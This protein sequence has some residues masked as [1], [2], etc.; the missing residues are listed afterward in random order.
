[1]YFMA[2]LS[3]VCAIASRLLALRWEIAPRSAAEHWTVAR[4]RVANVH[5]AKTGSLYLG[6]A[7]VMLGVVAEILR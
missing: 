6:G 4:K 3:L 2:L 5:A 7:A 1:M